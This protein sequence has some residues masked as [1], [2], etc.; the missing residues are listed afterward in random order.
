M[1]YL[2]VVIFNIIYAFPGVFAA[3]IP[4]SDMTSYDSSQRPQWERILTTIIYLR[5]DFLHQADDND[6][7]MACLFYVFTVFLLNPPLFLIF[8]LIHGFILLVTHLCDT[9]VFRSHE[10]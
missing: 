2:E 8:T 7:I 1:V 6:K 4:V 3:I 10:T 5:Q 9:F